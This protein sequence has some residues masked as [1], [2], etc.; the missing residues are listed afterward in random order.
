MREFV[1]ETRNCRVDAKNGVV[2]LS[3][4]FD[5]FSSDFVAFESERGNPDPQLIDYINRYRRPEAQIPT[6]YKVSFFD[7][8]KRL[9]KQ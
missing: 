3:K 5:W 8:D 6:T 1:G 2:T 7:Y 4:I 9:N